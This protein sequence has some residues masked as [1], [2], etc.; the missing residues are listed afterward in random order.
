MTIMAAGARFLLAMQGAAGWGWGKGDF[1]RVI[2]DGAATLLVLL[3]CTAGGHLASL[4]T[5]HDL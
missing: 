5:V 1:W 4:V 3:H 2:D